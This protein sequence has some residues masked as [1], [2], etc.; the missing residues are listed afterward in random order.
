MKEREQL[1][2]KTEFKVEKKTKTRR[3]EQSTMIIYDQML[4]YC[5]V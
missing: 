1:K 5:C 4:K 2:K 3:D